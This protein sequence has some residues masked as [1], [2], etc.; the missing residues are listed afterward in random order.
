MA[1]NFYN[2]KDVRVLSLGT[3]EKPYTPIKDA[4]KVT[5]FDYLKK[6]DEFITAID[7][8][9]ADYWLHTFMKNDG[10]N[11]HRAQVESMV[12]LDGYKEASQLK[13]D[14]T[15][16]YEDSKKEINRIIEDIIDEKYGAKV[17]K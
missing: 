3:G 10:Q 17:L 11:Y 12:E 9:T 8:Y 1:K 14:G 6:L 2:A 7:I 15:K 4:T 5:F 13:A 16:M